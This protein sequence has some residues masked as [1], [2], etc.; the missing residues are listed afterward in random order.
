MLHLR[1][2]LWRRVWAVIAS[3]TIAVVSGAVI[4]TLVAGG[5]AYTVITLTTRLRR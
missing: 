1:T 5:L 3:S 4:A 2:A